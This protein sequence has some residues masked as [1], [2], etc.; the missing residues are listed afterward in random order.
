MEVEVE[1]SATLS[2]SLPL[3]LSRCLLLPPQALFPLDWE[4][5]SLRLVGV[6]W[7]VWWWWWWVGGGGV[8]PPGRANVTQSRRRNQVSPASGI[9]P[10]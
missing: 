8:G 5:Q 1:G 3:S 7:G 4:E 6:W 9:F 2:L 10:P